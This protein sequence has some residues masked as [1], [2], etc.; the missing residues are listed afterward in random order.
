MLTVVN[1]G[2]TNFHAH[3]YGRS[4]DGQFGR[5]SQILCTQDTQFGGWHGAGHAFY[6]PWTQADGRIYVNLPKWSAV[7]FRLQ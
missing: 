7:M 4:N 1:L 5:W 2:E 6:D 3:S